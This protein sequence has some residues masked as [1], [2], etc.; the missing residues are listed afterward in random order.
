MILSRIVLLKQVDEE[1]A[2]IQF[3]DTGSIHGNSRTTLQRSLMYVQLHHLTVVYIDIKRNQ[4]HK[5]ELLRPI[6]AEPNDTSYGTPY[7]GFR[8]FTRHLRYLGPV[9][10][11][12]A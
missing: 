10:K 5:L 12:A 7:K 2:D 3:A 6:K 4:P 8:I 11:V 1:R 9:A